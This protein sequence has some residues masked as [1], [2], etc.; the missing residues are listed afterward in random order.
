MIEVEN[1]KGPLRGLRTRLAARKEESE[2]RRIAKTLILEGEAQKAK[3]QAEYESLPPIE[4]AARDA[5]DAAN[6]LENAVKSLEENINLGNVMTVANDVKQIEILA[7][8]ATEMAQKASEIAEE[9]NKKKLM[10]KSAPKE[11]EKEYITPVAPKERNEADE[12]T[13]RR[14]ELKIRTRKLLE[15][16]KLQKPGDSNDIFVSPLV[17]DA[18]KS[19]I[20]ARKQAQAAKSP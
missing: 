3:L 6:V 15:K 8:K 18:M 2:K 11:I 7:K 4:R 14:M 1:R 9:E 20:A 16:R 19:P 10:K 17:P 5:V 13:R 12:A